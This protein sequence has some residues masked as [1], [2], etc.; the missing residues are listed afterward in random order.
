MYDVHGTHASGSR[1][2]NFFFG[3]GWMSVTIII[4]VL[5]LRLSSKLPQRRMQVKVQPINIM[6]CGKIVDSDHLK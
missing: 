5:H 6:K 2:N 3:G 4:L 1:R